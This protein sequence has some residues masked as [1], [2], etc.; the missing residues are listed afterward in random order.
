MLFRG[1]IIIS[2][3]VIAAAIAAD[4]TTVQLHAFITRLQPVACSM[5]APSCRNHNQSSIKQEARSKGEEIRGKRDRVW[6]VIGGCALLFSLYVTSWRLLALGL[7]Q[8]TSMSKSDVCAVPQGF[9]LKS[10]KVSEK[11]QG[12]SL[13]EMI[14]VD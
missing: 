2:R 1:H 7:H 11:C 6:H 9:R 14:G 3:I 4:A 8:R 13:P 5:L 10:Y 12:M